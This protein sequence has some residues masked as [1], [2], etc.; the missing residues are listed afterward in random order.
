MTTNTLNKKGY[1]YPA[2]FRGLIEAAIFTNEE[3]LCEDADTEYN[4]QPAYQGDWRL[5]KASLSIGDFAPSAIAYLEDLCR[6]FESAFSEFCINPEEYLLITLRG[7]T[8]LEYVGHDIWMTC[9]RVGVGF[10]DGDWE[11]AMGTQLSAWCDK[12]SEPDI[13]FGSDKLIYVS[14][15]E[16]YT[17]D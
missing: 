13:Y 9:S 5:D 8:A 15:K 1:L 10:W 14:G 2:M 12:H 7:H 17:N 6:E 16:D 3:Q 11:E 4:H